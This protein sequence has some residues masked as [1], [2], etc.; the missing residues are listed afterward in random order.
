MKH[1]LYLIFT[2]CAHVTLRG[3]PDGIIWT[4]NIPYKCHGH[5]VETALPKKARQAKLVAS[6]I[7]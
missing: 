1:T 6:S 3:L 4:L 5:M 2:S 7:D